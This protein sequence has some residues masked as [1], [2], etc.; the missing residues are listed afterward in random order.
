MRSRWLHWSGVKRAP[1]E[2]KK[3][4]PGTIPGT[5]SENRRS[6]PRLA[7]PEREAPAAGSVVGRVE[8]EREEAHECSKK[9]VASA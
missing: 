5:E 2:R 4:E 1:G 6:G 8:E 9:E 3:R 7:T